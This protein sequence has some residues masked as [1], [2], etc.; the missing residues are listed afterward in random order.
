MHD[1]FRVMVVASHP[2]ELRDVEE[3]HPLVEALRGLTDEELAGVASSHLAVTHENGH[4]F[5][6]A[7]TLEGAEH[8]RAAVEL[9]MAKH[10]INGEIT[11]SRWHPIEERWEDPSIALP[12][13][14]DERAHERTRLDEQE[15]AESDS[16]GHPEWEVRITLPTHHDARDFAARLESEG[17]PV[18]QRWRHVMVGAN[19]EDEAAQLADRLRGEA[20]EG[21]EVVA[22]GSGAAV[23]EVAPGLQRRL[24]VF[25]GL[26]W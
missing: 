11:I 9:A 22:Q 2:R 20:P 13:T 6:Y 24:A 4:V 23:W 3:E 7:D 19:N 15:T 14:D 1:E 10:N 12:T 26:G 8:A 16:W 21:S 25:G 18:I 5:L 17:I